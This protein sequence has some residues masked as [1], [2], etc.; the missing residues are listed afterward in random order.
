MSTKVRSL[1]WVDS[2]RDR[3]KRTA[4]TTTTG[5]T[6]LVIMD[7]NASTAAVG[8]GVRDD[9]TRIYIYESSADKSTWTLRQT[10]G[11]PVGTTFS[12]NIDTGVTADLFT[13]NS[14]ALAFR[15]ANGSI[16]HQKVTTGTWVIGT[17]EVVATNAGGETWQSIDMSISDGNAVLISAL[18]T[19][20]TSGNFCGARNFLRRTTPATW[21]QI[22]SNLVSANTAV[23]SLTWD[24]SC[25][26][27]P[28]GTT[29]AREFAYSY[30]ATTSVADLGVT[31]VRASVDETAGATTLSLVG[32]ATYTQ[33]D[34]SFSLSTLLKTR[35]IM[36]FP[37][38]TG[39]FTFSAQT[40]YTQPKFN[41]SRWRKVGATWT[42]V[43]P[44]VSSTS[45]SSTTSSF[46][47]MTQS[48]GTDV[49]T[50]V[51]TARTGTASTW[52]LQA[53]PVRFNRA[54]DTVDF[55]PWFHFDNGNYV[56]PYFP[57]GGT[58]RNY[59]FRNHDIVF[60]R[61]L[62]STQYDWYHAFIQPMRAPLEI[63]PRAGSTITT[64][65]PAV[66]AQAD[67]DR[68]YSQGRIKLRWDFAKDS[69]FTTSLRSFTQSDL[70]FSK[71]D[72]TGT[73]AAPGYQVPENN[74]G[75]GQTS[76]ILF[77]DVLPGALTLDQGVWWVRA[78]HVSEYGLTSTFTTAQQFAVS[79]PPSAGN[80]SP[81]GSKVFAFG[82]GSREFLW[83]FTDSSPDDFQTAYQ[84]I[85]ERTSDSSVAVDTGKIFSSTSGDVEVLSPTLKDIELRWK[86]RL[87]DR[88]DVVG[89]YSSYGTF[90]MVDP[91][92]VAITAPTANQVLTSAIP[93]ITFT[94]T[95]AGT[96]LISK[97][98]VL[99][100]LGL[101][102][103]HDSGFQN[104]G[105]VASGTSLTYAPGKSVFDNLSGY[106]I[107]VRA[108]DTTGLEG[109]AVVAVT[110]SWTVPAGAVGTAVNILPYNTEDQGY[111]TVTW[112]D[113][114]RDVDFIAW[115]VQRKD[116][117]IDAATLAVLEAGTW[118]TLDY[119]YTPA[120]TYS[121]QDFYA[122]SGYRVQYKVLQMVDR[123]GDQVTSTNTATVDVYPISDGYWLI[124][125]SQ[126]NVTA[127][128]F[129]LS[130]VTSDTYTDEYEEDVYV[131]IGGG[132]H[133]EIGDHLGLSGTLNAQLR[134]NGG[135]SA[136]QKKRRLELMKL[137]TQDLF[138]RTPF[139]DIYR[140]SVGNL[141]ISRIAGTG[142][143]EFVD[144]TIPYLEV[145]E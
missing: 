41:V 118:Q 100:T 9:L 70:K 101:T 13:D 125:P 24:I 79:H 44:L 48:Y 67:L 40:F 106:T 117:I 12:D 15:C 143:D 105:N 17:A 68:N 115:V 55:G 120:T 123:F 33:N 66:S 130:I 56:S 102:V 49:L 107:T 133:K 88:D 139:G 137:G 37:S 54:N 61:R 19:T 128:A 43:T 51:V 97:Y 77:Q 58:G 60:G 57:Q 89:A 134:N 83:K 3:G 74:P 81:V 65:L 23:R 14:I 84:I 96:R 76:Q 93:T 136:R 35:S 114:N 72:F 87:W 104:A 112:N 32:L 75:K 109:Q 69:N 90:T 4:L 52:G 113:V 144:V 53:T 62:S 86:V 129:R 141:G 8:W 135:N 126:L 103:V 31:L 7:P 80:M 11:P 59:N 64:S 140:V 78:A 63:V 142:R 110:T 132:R 98:R 28:G 27:I 10:L 124:E 73:T 18:Y 92:T 99:V 46:G 50:F 38:G 71:V 131:V 145:G 25:T 21:A 6:I 108:T 111:I 121:Y 16:Y 34:V 5:T 36:L 116:D 119:I 138:L 127:D 91:P 45:T 20:V 30:C 47:S 85:I 82:T 95:V 39:E 94:P 42:N 26:W 2:E 22:S 29:T 1:G 122:P